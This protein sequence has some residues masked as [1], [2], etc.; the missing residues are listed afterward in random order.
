MVSMR[1]ILVGAASLLMW[2]GCAAVLAAP[3]YRITLYEHKDFQG[4]SLTYGAAVVNLSSS[5]LNDRTS[6]V[7]VVPGQKWLLCKNK[8]F[9]GGCIVIDRDVS[10]LADLGF[11]DMI[12]SLKP[13]E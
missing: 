12:S 4:R 6:S 9:R 5:G 1:R 8:K 3:V 11:N 7:K 2:G 10:D 13:V